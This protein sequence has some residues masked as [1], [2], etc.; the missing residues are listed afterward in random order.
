MRLQL[1]DLK[2]VKNLPVSAASGLVCYKERLYIIA[3]DE[4]E[5]LLLDSHSSQR[6]SLLTGELPQT[7]EA[8]KKAKP[9][10]EALMLI[11][12]QLFAL[13]SGSKP[14]RSKAVMISIPDHQFQ[15]FYLTSLYSFIAPMIKDLNLEGATLVGDEIWLFNRGNGAGRANYLIKL[16]AKTFLKE[17]SLGEVSSQVFKSLTTLSI[18]ES[19]GYP[20][21]VTDACFDDGL[22]YFVAVA[23]ATDSTYDDGQYL[24]AVF[25]ILDSSGQVNAQVNLPIEQKPEGM[26]VQGSTITIVTDADD[27]SVSSGLY[28]ST[29]KLNMNLKKNFINK[30]SL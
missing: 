20:L 3:D 10:F 2:L 29:F 25:G 15:V 4:N 9:D 8:R 11:G 27:R 28:E 5:L 7:P 14:N 22:V 23:E 13:P 26:W 12:N 1:N 21:G 30:G 24:G 18:G 17:A 19:N 6:L 16:D